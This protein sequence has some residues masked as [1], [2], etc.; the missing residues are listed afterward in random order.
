M[1]EQKIDPKVIDKVT[2]PISTTDASGHSQLKAKPT[3]DELRQFLALT[4]DQADQ[5]NI[6]DEPFEVDVVEQFDQAVDKALADTGGAA[7]HSTAGQ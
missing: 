5:A 3:A 1:Y 6:P 4:K 7:V 2:Q